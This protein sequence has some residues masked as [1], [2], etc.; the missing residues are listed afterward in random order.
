MTASA[1]PNA[2]EK[3]QLG[4]WHGLSRLTHE[5]CGECEKF[6]VAALEPR[7]GSVE[8]D[9]TKCGCESRWDTFD[10]DFD[11]VWVKH[12]LEHLKMLAGSISSTQNLPRGRN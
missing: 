9:R 6:L 11:W 10:T 12:V 8:E 1:P 7:K 2:A 4:N 3:G 5:D